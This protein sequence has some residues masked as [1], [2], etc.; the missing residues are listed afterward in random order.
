MER[1][2][3]VRLELYVFVVELILIFSLIVISPDWRRIL[4]YTILGFVLFRFFI[5][6]NY[7]RFCDSYCAGVDC[8]SSVLC[9]PVLSETNGDESLMDGSGGTSLSDVGDDNEFGEHE[10]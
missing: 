9:S 4:M 5:V 6:P 1:V 3:L 8:A 10:F 7:N 2:C